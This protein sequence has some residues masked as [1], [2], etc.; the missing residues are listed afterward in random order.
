MLTAGASTCAC[1]AAL[2]SSSNAAMDL[3]AMAGG[4]GSSLLK[5]RPLRP[6]HG[7]M[8]VLQLSCALTG[9]SW[10]LKTAPVAA[11]RSPIYVS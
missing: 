1:A 6:A 7:G 3:A 4:G 8:Q 2:I 9:A 10:L 5:S 11:P